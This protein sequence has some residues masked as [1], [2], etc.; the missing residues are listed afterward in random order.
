MVDQEAAN[1]R[2]RRAFMGP[3]PEPEPPQLP[4][5]PSAGPNGSTPSSYLE[6][7]IPK[8]LY[9][10]EVSD[11][12]TLTSGQ[13]FAP[14]EPPATPTSSSSEDTLIRQMNFA[15]RRP[16][17]GEE[18]ATTILP[19]PHSAGRMPPGR[20]DE[21]DDFDDD[22][23]DRP[24]LGQRAKLAL[25]ISGV[26]AVVVL[27]LAVGY[28]VL[29]IGTQPGTV[30]STAPSSV[31]TDVAPSTEPSPAESAGALL[32]DEFM[33][34][35]EQAATLDPDRR[36]NVELTQRGASEDSP[37][38]TCFGGDPVEGQPA[39]Q[40]RVIQVLSSSGKK[41]PSAL[42]EATAYTTTEEASQAFAVASR[43]IGG[44]A[45]VG[46]YIE[47]GRVVSGL[48]DQ[49][50]AIVAK[51]AGK[52][53]VPHNVVLSR[54]GRVLNLLDVT[55]PGDPLR[56]TTTAKALGE[57]IAVQCGPAGGE[58][59]GAIDVKKGPPPIGGDEPGFLAT[60]DL[61]PAGPEPTE[62]SATPIDLPK[63]DFSGSGCENTNWTTVPAEERSSRIYLL[64]ESGSAFFGVNEIVLTLKDRKAAKRLAG[65]IQKYLTSC[66]DRKLTADVSKPDKVSSIGARGSEITGYTAV[67]R[68][69]AGSR[70]TKFRVGVVRTDN[71]LIYTFANP[72]E[73]YD[74]TNDQWD[75][76]AVRAGER[77]TQIN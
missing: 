69:K 4:P 16:P 57:V 9:R 38:A 8:P 63:D 61:P 24:G 54:S 32:T 66:K 15:P 34:S 43:T 55:A 37:V 22:D 59:G 1:Y 62:W 67:V 65:D 10:D 51:V 31:V 49:A 40:Q 72:T 53:L 2:P 52:D 3:D 11:A 28:A 41:A 44:C 29:G 23:E 58:C 68:Q 21:L 45:V 48:G 6:E 27:G 50:T 64:Q 17:R 47:S 56:V 71:K 14:V 30:P 74:F 25:L 42:H 12:P 5:G 7:D 26:A 75:T 39:S 18:E 20:L 77:I 33:L 36:W 19:R 76:I 46:S 13:P 60:G 73:G 35:P 70:T